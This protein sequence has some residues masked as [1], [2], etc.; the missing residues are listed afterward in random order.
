MHSPKK[1]AYTASAILV[2]TEIMLEVSMPSKFD[3]KNDTISCRKHNNPLPHRVAEASEGFNHRRL[4]FLFDWHQE[5][6]DAQSKESS[7]YCKCHPSVHGNN[8]RGAHAN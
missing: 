4:N 5:V 8:A 3:M 2:C 1:V 7:L 6:E